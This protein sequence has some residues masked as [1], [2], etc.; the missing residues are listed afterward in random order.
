MGH[1]DLA[2]KGMTGWLPKLLLIF[3]GGGLILPFIIVGGVS[4]NSV[5]NIDFPPKGFT[6]SWYQS[7]VGEWQW[8]I[9]MWN[10][11]QIAMIAALLATSIA[12]TANYYLWKQRSAF[13]RII[14]AIGV[15]PFL[16]PSVILA[17]GA[18]ILWAYSGLYGTIIAT[19]ISHGVFFAPLPM[20]VVARGFAGLSQEVI[21]ASRMMGANK[22][23]IF[24]TIILPLIA[25]YVA[26]GFALV[27]IISFNEYII[28]N[29]ISG[30]IVET[31]PIKIFNSV[32]NGYSPMLASAAMGFV[33]L[34]FGVLF[35]VSRFTDLPALFGGRR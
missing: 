32:R 18:N 15:A 22:R 29:M 9:P 13:A 1:N 14:V 21:E 12:V 27:A 3:V 16:L 2:G 6:L 24:T 4:V 8:L 35:T 7:L 20:I 30:F 23:Q 33:I 17:L 19:M 34:T 10:S 25:P 11:A 28:S 5:S 31:L 26:T